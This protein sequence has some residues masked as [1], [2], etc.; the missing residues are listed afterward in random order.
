MVFGDLQRVLY[1]LD[2]Y[3]LLA[4]RKVVDQFGL[5]VSCGVCFDVS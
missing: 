3:L 2:L 1:L 5:E 4:D